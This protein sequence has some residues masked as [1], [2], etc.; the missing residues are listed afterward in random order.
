M[1]ATEKLIEA[2][3]RANINAAMREKLSSLITPKALVIAI[4]SFAA[5]F[6]ASQFT[7]VGWAADLG[8]ALTAIFVGNCVV[9]GYPAFDKFRQR[10]KCDHFRTA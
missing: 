1:T 8:I 6:I 10:P 5:V 3:D 9:H 4:I 7:P 2:Y